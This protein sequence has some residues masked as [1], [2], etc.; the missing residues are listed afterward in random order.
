MLRGHLKH[1]Q[2]GEFPAW[3]ACL[4]IN[5][6]LGEP[7]RLYLGGFGWTVILGLPTLRTTR[8]TGEYERGLEVWRTCLTWPHIDGCSRYRYRQDEEG[9]W[10]R[11]DRPEPLHWGWLTVSRRA[12]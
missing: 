7:N 12:E 4:D 10:V 1:G 6:P 2:A 9:N 5:P 3:S 8:F 11:K